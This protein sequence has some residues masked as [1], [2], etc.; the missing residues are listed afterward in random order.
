MADPIGIVASII[1]NVVRWV[2]GLLPGGFGLVL[3]PLAGLG[4]ISFL[5]ARNR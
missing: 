3:F 4:L 2:Q 1:E 5:V